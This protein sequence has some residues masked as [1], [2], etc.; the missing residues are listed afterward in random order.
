MAAVTQDTLP[1]LEQ[2]SRDPD[3]WTRAWARC[4]LSRFRPELGPA[5][6]EEMLEALKVG[7]SSGKAHALEILALLGGDAARAAPLA[8]EAVLTDS[9]STDTVISARKL[10][11][12]A[13]D[14]APIA[15]ALE[16]SDQRRKRFALKLF[17]WGDPG[18]S[19]CSL[20]SAIAGVLHAP[21]PVEGLAPDV[22]MEDDRLREFACQV[23]GNVGRACPEA[24]VPLKQALR[25][26]TQRI[27]AAA[28]Q[29]LERIERAER[30]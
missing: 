6:I 21:P 4:V 15:Q 2:A 30:P 3:R 19:A 7:D 11:T 13:G 8:I 14:V 18:P 17:V 9:F 10:I 26:P 20:V 22:L 29:A 5:L 1:L 25:E 27:R 28:R 24:I 16:G 12:S 23:L